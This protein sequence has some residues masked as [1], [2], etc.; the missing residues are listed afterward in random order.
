MTNPLSSF[1]F[2][3][4]HEGFGTAYEVVV[5]SGTL[6]SALQIPLVGDQDSSSKIRDLIFPLENIDVM[7]VALDAAVPTGS[8]LRTNIFNV[9]QNSYLQ[10]FDITAGNKS[11]DQLGGP[12][13]VNP[14]DQV[15]FVLVDILGS[16]FTISKLQWYI[17]H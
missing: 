12:L 13:S 17:K 10:N 8:T 16:G 2:V 11:I 15:Y 14:D 9:T 1:G 7:A 5:P 3:Q 4:G 6:S